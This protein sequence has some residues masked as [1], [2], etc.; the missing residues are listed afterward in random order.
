MADYVISIAA[1]RHAG[2]G[3]VRIEVLRALMKGQGALT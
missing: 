2:K 3:W 1:H